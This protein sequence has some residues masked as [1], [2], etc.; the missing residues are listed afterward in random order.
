MS[1]KRDHERFPVTFAHPSNVT[2][3]EP[4]LLVLC[5]ETRPLGKSING[6]VPDTP[7]GRTRRPPAKV[8]TP[9]TMAF[10]GPADTAATAAFVTIVPLVAE[11][12]GELK[13][14]LYEG[15]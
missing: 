1:N 9:R 5:L 8:A 2:P 15:P 13:L 10:E 6:D 3:P 11:P 4:P 14:Y 12:S 7:P